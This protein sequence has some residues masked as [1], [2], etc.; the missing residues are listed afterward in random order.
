VGRGNA[1]RKIMACHNSTDKRVI[2]CKGYLAQDGWNNLNVRLL[3]IK[4]QM[5]DPGAVAEACDAE[6]IELE[7]DN[8]T[9][10]GEVVSRTCEHDTNPITLSAGTSTGS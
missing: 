10:F 6:G 2:P 8:E 3:A 4:G 7:P 1:F 5:P 9:V